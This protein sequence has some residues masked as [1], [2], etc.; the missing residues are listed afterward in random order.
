MIKK[1]VVFRKNVLPAQVPSDPEIGSF[2]ITA[3]MFPTNFSIFLLRVE[4]E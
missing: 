1:L 3:E 2:D 4:K